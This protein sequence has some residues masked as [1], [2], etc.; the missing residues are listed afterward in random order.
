MKLKRLTHPKKLSGRLFDALES[1]ILDGEL[2]AG[3][4][5]PTEADLCRQLGVSRT[6]LREA[7]QQ[8]K[9]CG[10]VESVPGVG[11]FVRAV[12]SEAVEKELSRFAQLEEDAGSFSELVEFR[13]LF[14][15]E[16]ARQAAK[17][18]D[19][20]CLAELTQQL[21]EMRANLSNVSAFMEADLDMHL[22]IARQAEN[23][24]INLVLC[25]LKPLTKRFGK[26]NHH[27]TEFMK[28]TIQEHERILV[29]IKKGDGRAAAQAMRAHLLS[30]REHF[31]EH[32]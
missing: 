27:E 23:R 14:E 7:L 4:R 3:D 30:S 25:C 18:R 29:A 28:V 6:S 32:N 12:S 1:M 15:P 22:A 20:A 10:L 9:G 13:L 8:L 21:D 5:L 17:R 16:N 2:R 19:P 24:F 31:L 11:M 26:I